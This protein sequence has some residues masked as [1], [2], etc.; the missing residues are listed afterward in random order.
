MLPPYPS[1]LLFRATA[2]VVL[3]ICL[4]FLLYLGS[5]ILSP[6]AVAL[7]LCL[8]L[9]PLNRR[10]ERM[11][12][13]RTLAIILC[14]LLVMVVLVGLIWFFSTQAMG[15]EDQV[16]ALLKRSE[17]L[18]HQSQKWVNIKFHVTDKEQLKYISNLGKN[19]EN[20]G[21]WLFTTLS[22][23]T[24]DLITVLGIM[25]IYLFFILY[26]RS[27]YMEFLTKLFDEHRKETVFKIAADIEKVSQNYLRGLLTVI[28]I[29]ATLNSIGLYILGIENPLF[30]G[31]LASLL[32]VIPY[33]GIAIGSILPAV[34]AL[35][36]K[37]S[38]WYSAG[39]IALM[40]VVQFLEGNFITPMIVG[41]RV[42]INQI[43]AVIALL[44]AGS[45]WGPVGMILAIPFTAIIKVICD[46]VEELKPYGFI[47]G[48]A[49]DRPKSAKKT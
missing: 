9:L 44:I 20:Q 36:T 28:L 25:P 38:A 1:P 40:F 27:F 2:A 10:L 15:F 18:L 46:N 31:A 16:P 11:G 32:A 42:S 3:L 49:P 23:L 6:L 37:D 14:I 13:P 21:G 39:V 30:F 41:K 5:F 12:L 45:L 43:A 29:V 33:I 7:L 47:L 35:V 48:E 26:Y 4:G 22:G 24:G 8:L 19:L 17:T 34:I